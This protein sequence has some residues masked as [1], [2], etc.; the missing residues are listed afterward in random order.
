MNSSPRGTPSAR[1]V[2]SRVTQDFERRK[3]IQDSIASAD[4]HLLST[5]LPAYLEVAGALSR[6]V[7][8]F[9]VHRNSD[10]L[11]DGREVLRR[12]GRLGFLA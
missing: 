6:V 10:A 9:D 4:T 1:I 11:C 12:L 5:G 7:L 2:G 8:D 3:A